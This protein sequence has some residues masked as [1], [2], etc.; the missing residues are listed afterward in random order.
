MK[1]PIVLVVLIVFGVLRWRRA[2]LLLWAFAW[3][4]GIYAVIRFG[5]VAPTGT[6]VTGGLN[7]P[8]LP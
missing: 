3:W 4:V 5:F 1:I 6:L 2:P 7:P 8:L